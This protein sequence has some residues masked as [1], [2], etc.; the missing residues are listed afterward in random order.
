MSAARQTGGQLN[1]QPPGLNIYAEQPCTENARF[2]MTGRGAGL[3]RLRGTRC[4][5]A[6]GSSS[7]R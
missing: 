5:A 7:R 3:P 1:M 4:Y 6:G 2:C